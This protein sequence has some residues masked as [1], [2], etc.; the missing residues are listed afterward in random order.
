[1]VKEQ[2]FLDTIQE[3]PDYLSASSCVHRFYSIADISSVIAGHMPARGETGEFRPVFDA[4]RK[5][6][7]HAPIFIFGKSSIADHTCYQS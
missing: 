3:A 1:M 4:I 5:L 2:W 6:H 7:P